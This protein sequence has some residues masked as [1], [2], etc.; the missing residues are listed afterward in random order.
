MLL[1]HVASVVTLNYVR[2]AVDSWKFN[3]FVETDIF[4]SYGGWLIM[5]AEEISVTL[6]ERKDFLN[7]KFFETKKGNPL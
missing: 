5:S 6:L 2:Y 7:K 4:V 3:T 1:S